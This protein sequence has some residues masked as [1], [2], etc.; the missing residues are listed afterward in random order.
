MY[1]NGVFI[2]FNSCCQGKVKYCSWVLEILSLSCLQ[3]FLALVAGSHLGWS[4]YK[5]FKQI[6]ARIILTQTL[7]KIYLESF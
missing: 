1:L 7:V 5:K 6:L 3:L 2:R 4:I